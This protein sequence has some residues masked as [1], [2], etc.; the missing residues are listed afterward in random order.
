MLAWCARTSAAHAVWSLE[1]IAE[2]IERD[3][4][5]RCVGRWRTLL[6]PTTGSGSRLRL[7]VSCKFTHEV[8]PFL[9]TRTIA[10]LARVTDENGEYIATSVYCGAGMQDG[11]ARAILHELMQS[12]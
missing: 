10:E 11:A 2:A 7:N 5:A 4:W 12:M 1:L 3:V 9:A 6:L 8:R